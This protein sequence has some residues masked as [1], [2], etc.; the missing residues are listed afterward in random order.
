[1]DFEFCITGRIANIDHRS[2]FHGELPGS[3]GDEEILSF[4][5]DR[6]NLSD[7]D[8]EMIRNVESFA[9]VYN[10][11]TLKRLADDCTSVQNRVSVNY[12]Q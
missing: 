9:L 3:T 5:W 11:L 7:K 1:M 2:E 12:N 4:E 10:L 8:R 6:Q